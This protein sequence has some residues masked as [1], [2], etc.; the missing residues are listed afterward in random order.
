MNPNP[1]IIVALDVQ[2]L[3]EA[4]GL[5]EMLA[6][7]VTA[8]KVGKQLC[9]AEGVP[10]VLKAI[11]GKGGRAFLDLKFHDIPNTVEQAVKAAADQGVW[12]TNM[13]TT[14]GIKAMVAANKAKQNTLLIGVTVLTSLDDNECEQIYGTNCR[15][16]VT[17]LM[18]RA[19]DSGLDGVVCSPLE[20]S[21]TK[22]FV[23]RDGKAFLAVTPGIRPVGVDTNDQARS[24]SPSYA[25]TQRA[26]FLVIGRAITHAEDPLSA[27]K[28]I[29]A[30]LNAA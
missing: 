7:H 1:G 26:D 12:M 25:K 18:Q 21:V 17:S 13:H 22:Q 10:T 14:A 16:T 28:A 2:T 11:H 29:E 9:T 23:V 27:I 4:E 5:I 24:T 3:R 19:Y 6:E 15:S 8:F 20:A 30:Q